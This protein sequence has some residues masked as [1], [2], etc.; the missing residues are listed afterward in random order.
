[1]KPVIM[2]N[3]KTYARAT[4]KKALN[5]ARKISELTKKSK[6]KWVVCP[7]HIDLWMAKYMEIPVYAQH[8]DALE[9]GR[10]TGYVTPYSLKLYGIKGSLINHSEHRLSVKEIKA[11]IE[12]LKKYKMVSV[13]CANSVKEASKLARLKPDYIAVEPPEL[14]GTGI[15]VSEAQPEIVERSAK[16]V[17][18]HGVKFLC[19]AGISKGD[20]VKRAIELGADGVLVA[21][22]IANSK[23]PVKVIKDFLK[24]VDSD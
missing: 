23:N 13:V 4:G 15:S 14:I 19:G 20:D 16:V 2:V 10:G 22:A 21:S 3:F 24:G 8:V 17:K 12:I 7:Q 1:M 11:R 5:L 18:K 6:S 9:P